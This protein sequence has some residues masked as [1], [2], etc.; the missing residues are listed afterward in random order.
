MKFTR[1]I[2]REVDI[3]DETYIVSFD[4]TGV[5]FRIKGKRKSIKAG[6]PELLESAHPSSKAKTTHSQQPEGT[7]SQPAL[8]TPTT[9]P[10]GQESA[11]PQRESYSTSQ[12]STSVKTES[13]KEEPPGPQRGE[14]IGGVTSGLHR[15]VSAGEGNSES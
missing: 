6:W 10:F 8:E 2:S 7:R 4:E 5:D 3:N 15:T 14:E 12:S 9:Q 1:P 13:I 11:M